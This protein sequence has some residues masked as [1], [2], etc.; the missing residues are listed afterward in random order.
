LQVEDR[1]GIMRLPN[2]SSTDC[3]SRCGWLRRFWFSCESAHGY[4]RSFDYQKLTFNISWSSPRLPAPER[5]SVPGPPADGKHAPRSTLILTTAR[6]LA[7][8]PVVFRAGA[9]DGAPRGAARSPAEAGWSH[10]R[11]VVAASRNAPHLLQKRSRRIEVGRGLYCSSPLN[12]GF[13]SSNQPAR[14]GPRPRK[15]PASG[16]DLPRTCAT[17]VTL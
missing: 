7:T 17:A 3:R 8:P 10:D 13:S 12:R 5:R 2:V 14:R 16:P 9:E 15:V 4:F 6:P 1:V 11:I